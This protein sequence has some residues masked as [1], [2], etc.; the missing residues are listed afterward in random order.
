M[1]N[2]LLDVLNFGNA[3]VGEFG[4]ADVFHSCRAPSPSALRTLLRESEVFA[5]QFRVT[6][7]AAKTQ[8][9]CFQRVKIKTFLPSLK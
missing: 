7:N 4:S 8:L 6:F 1:I 2:S 3:F 9:I 5:L